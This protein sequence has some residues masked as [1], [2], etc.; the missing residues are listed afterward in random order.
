[1]GRKILAVVALLGRRM[2]GDRGEPWH[3]TYEQN[4]IV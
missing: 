3:G 1:M 4:S 2:S